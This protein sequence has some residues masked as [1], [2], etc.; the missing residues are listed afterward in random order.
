MD[1]D[2]QSSIDPGV[3]GDRFGPNRDREIPP[4]FRL[5]K[6]V[7]MAVAS[8]LAVLA[9]A[10]APAGAQAPETAPGSEI[11]SEPL[12]PMIDQRLQQMSDF[13]GQTGSFTVRVRSIFDVPDPSRQ[14]RIKIGAETEVAVRRPDRLHARSRREDRLNAELWYDGTTFAVLWPG[15]NEY[16]S[17]AAPGTID[18]L[19]VVLEEDYGVHLPAADLL[20]NDPAGVIRQ[21]VVS[22]VYLGQ[23]VIDGVPCDH[24]AFEST[25]A[26]WQLWI[27]SGERPLPCRLSITLINAPGEP[28]YLA[29]FHDWTLGPEL[30][31][32][33]FSFDPP[34]DAREIDLA[35]RPQPTAE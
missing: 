31:D 30:D 10:F 13:L 25:G 23:R 1:R 9:A 4:V 19:L 35:E 2:G 21:H 24:F 6:F 8:G 27:E 22:G 5:T 7:T 16:G 26:N 20:Y 15:R 3:A 17:F 18:E 12:H 32:A 11:A 28:E 33:T 34:A 29:S 14:I